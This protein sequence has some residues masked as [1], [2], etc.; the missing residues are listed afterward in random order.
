[1]R[2]GGA[3]AWLD[4]AASVVTRY[5][6]GEM[7]YEIRD[8]VLGPGGVL[9]L[10]AVAL[11]QTDGLIVRVEFV[12]GVADPGI[13]PALAGPT[14]PVELVL[15]FGG[16]NGQRGRRDGDIGTE[17]VPISE[18]F[19]LQPEFCRDNRFTI[20]A[21]TFTL[22]STA[23]TMVG[24]APPDATLA[25]ADA[26]QWVSAA[27]LFGGT[28][29]APSGSSARTEPGPPPILPVVIGR[30]ALVSGRSLFF[31]LQ[32]ITDGAAA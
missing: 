27:D 5:R 17:A 31:S 24:L 21:N 4:A 15:A 16:V 12:A 20:V 23:A 14:A 26:T 7:L 18:Y 9:R 32:R 8:P 11:D 2:A 6:P 13:G 19:Q 25:V 3:A 30:V 29:A 1:M 10:T 28:A 22:R